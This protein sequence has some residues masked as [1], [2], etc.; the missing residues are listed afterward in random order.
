[1]ETREIQFFLL[2]HPCL[3]GWMLGLLV[4]GSLVRWGLDESAQP[5]S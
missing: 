4:R 2:Q 3:E 5:G 1:M